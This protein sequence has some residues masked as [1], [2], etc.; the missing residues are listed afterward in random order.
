LQH[1]SSQPQGSIAGREKKKRERE[2]R[3]HADPYVAEEGPPV[4]PEE[5]TIDPFRFFFSKQTI[6][7][8][9]N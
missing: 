6:A 2:K 8:F 5:F 7:P 4:V 3:Q 1:P 9:S